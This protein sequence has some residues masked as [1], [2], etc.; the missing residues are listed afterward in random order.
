MKKICYFINSDWYFDLHWLERAYAAQKEGY[1]VHVMTRFEGETFYNKFTNLGFVCHPIYLRE[2]SLNPFGFLFS[3]LNVSL[4]LAKLKPSIVHSITIKP[5][6]IGGLFSRIKNIPFVANI[7]GLGRV[8]DCNGI[9]YHVI[10][11]LVISTYRYIFRN[12]KSKII[13]EHKKDMNILGEFIHF[14]ADQTNIIDGAGVDTKL[15]FY[16][17]EKEL[18]KPIVFF[19]GRMLKNKGLKTLI[20]IKSELKEKNIHFDLVVAGIEVPDDPNAIPSSM[21]TAWHERGDIIWLGTRRDIAQLITS[22]SIVALPTIYPEGIPRIL[23]EACAIGRPCIAY[24][25][26]GCS[27]I[28]NNGVTGYLIAKNDR[29]EFRD[30]LVTLIMNP[31]LR[32]KMG[33][34]GRDL[35]A[36]RFSSEKI[37]HKTLNI[38]YKLAK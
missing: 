25:S 34:N 38:Y 20:E 18:I 24:N 5:I 3:M 17:E 1:Q 9:V 36:N 30:K 35:V 31:E 29:N 8:F 32:K 21:L 7:V 27:S 10:K 2:R 37:T 11:K 19:A 4:K 26:G 22:A 16:Q 23:I 14:Q 12:R 33:I 28:I 13:F 15:F 6:I